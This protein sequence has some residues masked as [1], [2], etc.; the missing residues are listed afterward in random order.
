MKKDT[1]VIIVCAGNSTRMGGV[2]KILLPLGNSC[3]IGHTMKAFEN[4]ESVAEIIIVA[5]ECDHDKIKE[6]AKKENITKFAGITVG[7]KVRQESVKNGLKLISKDTDI[8]AVHDGARPLVSPENIE[9]TIKDARVFGGSTLGVRVKDTIKV[10]EDDLIVD[11]PYRPSLFIC[12]TPQVFKRK[13]YF[14][15]VAF[16]SEHNIENL[17]DDCQLAEAIGQKI[18]MT[19]G[20]YKNI[21]ITTP[22]DIKIAEVLLND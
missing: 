13:I 3:V 18:F 17:T 6:V 22:E 2:N 9:K 11:T 10:V 19:E 7:G 14:D 21:K 8:I 4:S 12:Q 16:A 20:D 5:R 15:A 1:S